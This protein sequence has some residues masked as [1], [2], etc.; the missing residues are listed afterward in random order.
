MTCLRHVAVSEVDHET[1][2]IDHTKRAAAAD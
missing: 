2:G 1:T